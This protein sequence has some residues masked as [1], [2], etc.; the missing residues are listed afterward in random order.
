M[1]RFYRTW[2]KEAR[3]KREQEGLTFN[4]WDKLGGL[5]PAIIIILIA[6]YLFFT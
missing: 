6:V 1:L 4:F 3:E 5:I 2:A